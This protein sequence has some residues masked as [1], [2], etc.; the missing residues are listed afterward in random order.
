VGGAPVLDIDRPDDLAF[1]DALVADT[2]RELES[3]ESLLAR[4]RDVRPITDDNMGT[5]W[6]LPPRYRWF[7]PGLSESPP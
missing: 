1:A 7:S 6:L 2:R 3:R 4:T 5:E